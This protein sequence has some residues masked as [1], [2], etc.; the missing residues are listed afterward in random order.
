M[1]GHADVDLYGGTAGAVTLQTARGRWPGHEERD[2]LAFPVAAAVLTLR[3]VSEDLAPRIRH[4]LMALGAALAEGPESRR[5]DVE[6]IERVA[7]RRMVPPRG[8]GAPRV[9]IRFVTT[10]EG[11]E[12][13]IDGEQPSAITLASACGALAATLFD[14]T[15]AEARIAGALAFEGALILSGLPAA[16]GESGAKLVSASLRYS[17]TRL[18][19]AGRELPAALASVEGSVGGCPDGRTERL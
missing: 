14:G 15:S 4:R 16:A 1:A 19:E 10:H 13:R 5:R 6:W 3:S 8:L 17:R 2:R 12:A 7:A 11:L 9:S 18:I